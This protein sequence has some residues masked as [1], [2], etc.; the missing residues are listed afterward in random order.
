MSEFGQHLAAA[1]H[2]CGD[3]ADIWRGQGLSLLD[4]SHREMMD[5]PASLLRLL[6]HAPSDNCNEGT[7]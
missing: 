5:S 2:H 1:E 6:V 7:L 4:W 3:W